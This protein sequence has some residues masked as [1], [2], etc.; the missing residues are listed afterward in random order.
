M[1]GPADWS[2]QQWAR[3]RSGPPWLPGP[4]DPTQPWP[5]PIPSW[6]W[7]GPWL[8]AREQTPAV[9]SDS[10]VALQRS[11]QDLI[12]GDLPRGKDECISRLATHYG[13]AIRSIPTGLGGAVDPSTISAFLQAVQVPE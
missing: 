2:A 13:D 1:S 6:P 7:P 3:L 5:W 4:F 12:S 8:F 10:V 11:L 9:N